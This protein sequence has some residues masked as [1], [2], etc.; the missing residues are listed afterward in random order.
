M[1]IPVHKPK[2]EDVLK[3]VAKFDDLYHTDGGLPDAAVEGYHRTFSNVLGFQQPEGA[4][5]YSPVGDEAKPFITHLK[6][7][8]GLAYVSARPGQGVMTHT[9]DTNETFVVMEGTW[10][11]QWEGDEGDEEVVL[12]EKDVISFEPGIQRRFECKTARDGAE[13]GVLL[14]VIGGDQPG[15]EYSPESVEKLKA[16]GVWPEDEAAE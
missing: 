5:T 9:H 4:E 8:F 3:C 6:P 16:A 13:K 11:L 7:G 15:G 1:P 10:K 12:E 2:K 14:G